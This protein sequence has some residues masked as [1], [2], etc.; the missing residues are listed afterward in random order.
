MG[1]IPEDDV[2]LESINELYDY[3]H[4]FTDWE[5]EFIEDMQKWDGPFTDGQRRKM[6][7]IIDRYE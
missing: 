4:D 3:G 5:I 6:Q 1:T 7:Q 2:L